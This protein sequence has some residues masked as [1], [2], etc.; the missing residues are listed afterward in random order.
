RQEARRP[1]RRAAQAGARVREEEQEPR[2][3][4]RAD[5][6]QDKGRLL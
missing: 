1:H 3:P 2:D 5:R 4:D 6:P